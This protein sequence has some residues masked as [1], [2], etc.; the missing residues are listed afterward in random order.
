MT[1]KKAAAIAASSGLVGPATSPDDEASSPDFIGS[2]SPV[3]SPYG[4]HQHIQT[5]D[6]D[7]DLSQAITEQTCTALTKN[8]W[9]LY[10]KDHHDS[11]KAI[12]P[13]VMNSELCKFLIPLPNFP[14]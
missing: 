1:K 12:Y 14:C 11:F 9:I 13:N 8:S 3:P 4:A 6:Y 5:A 2:P 10:R 7:M